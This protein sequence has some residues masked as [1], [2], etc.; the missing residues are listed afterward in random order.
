MKNLSKYLRTEFKDLDSKEILQNPITVLLGVDENALKAL[1][2]INV[3]TVFDL[4]ASWLFAN[5]TTLSEKNQITRLADNLD[6]KK[7]NLLKLNAQYQ[8]VE[9]IPELD[10]NFLYGI[11][12]SLANELKSA[13]DITTIRDFAYWP[14]RLIAHK[15][16]SGDMGTTNEEIDEGEIL[17]PKLGEYPT[18][19]VYF[20]SLTMLHMEVDGPQ[21]PIN[22]PI[23]LIPAINQPSGFGKPAVGVLLTTSQSWYAKG[24]TL[25]HMLHSLA[26]APGEATRIAVVDWSRKTSAS[27]TES[28]QQ[29]ESLNNVTNH[30]RAISEVQN[31][32]AKE[33]QEGQSMSSG[34]AESSSEANADAGSSGLIQSVL[35]ESSSASHSKQSSST[36]SGSV[37]TSWSRGSRDISSEMTQNVNDRTEQHANSVRNRR[38]TA[39]REVSQSEHESVSTRIVANYNH[40]HALTIQYY[41][42][43]QVYKVASQL[44]DAQRC[45]FIPFEYLDFSVP[46]AMD[47]VDRFRGALV[48]AALNSRARDLL[49]DTEPMVAIKPVNRKKLPFSDIAIGGGTISV[50][51][52][53]LATD[54]LGESPETETSEREGFNFEKNIMDIRDAV[55]NISNVIGRAPNRRGSAELYLPANTELLGI[56][57][58]NLSIKSIRADRPGISASNN[59]FN[60]NPD[61]GRIDFPVRMR[62]SDIK[63]IYLAKSKDAKEEGSVTLICS[64]EG[65]SFN[66]DAMLVELKEGTAMQKMVTFQSDQLDREKELLDHLQ[67]NRAHY[68]QMVFRLLDTATLVML[69][70]P[71]TWNG[72]SLIDQIEPKPIAVAGNFL[73]FKAPIENS[74][75]S[76]IIENGTNKTWGTILRERGIDFKISNIRLVPIPTAG[77][78][79]EA[80]LGRSN[81]AEKLDITRFWNWQDSPIPLQPSEISPI[82]LE[83]RGIQENLT[84]GDLNAPVLNIVNPTS[85]PDPAGLSA[86]LGAIAN[87]NIFRNM[88]GLQGTQSIIESAIRE[89]IAAAGQAGQLTT[90]NMQTEAQKQVALSQIAA[91][92]AKAALGIPSEKSTKGISADGAKVNLGRDMDKRGVSGKGSSGSDESTG[93]SSGG[94]VNSS[95]GSSG[96]GTNGT[97][98]PETRMTGSSRE[99]A[100]ADHLSLGYSPGGLN[101][102]SNLVGGKTILADYENT[103]NA[104]KE[105]S[106]TLDDLKKTYEDIRDKMQ[107]IQN[108]QSALNNLQD[109]ES[110]RKAWMDDPSDY[111]KGIIWAKKTAE[112]FKM[113]QDFIPSLPI[114]DGNYIKKLLGAVPTYVNKLTNLLEQRIAKIDTAANADTR[115]FNNDESDDQAC[116]NTKLTKTAVDIIMKLDATEID[117]RRIFA[118]SCAINFRRAMIAYINSTY[119]I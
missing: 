1:K 106:K 67:A 37:S 71:F 112:G 49:A 105:I 36:S 45:L 119:W 2:K 7:N 60:V 14:P 96:G 15:L 76:G 108:V 9:D 51:T 29:S 98:N 31:A 73:V 104:V 116:E 118:M 58:D 66:S 16:L 20:N 27:V 99:A 84:P 92:I 86:S 77:V 26:L 79:A 72:I 81:S 65:R 100:Y 88:S 54:T 39:V 64:Y 70:S 90:T 113:L 13:L 6:L 94:S 115:Y 102:L 63:E 42:V 57:F 17:R 11:T 8:S 21:N 97:V 87:G 74:E 107:T 40:M 52:R 23:S 22:S 95:E 5:A 53:S 103:N 3:E 10:L 68:S 33:M 78:F 85:L 101:A 4:G 43:V 61:I 109:M 69:I 25:G 44:H 34:W 48:R 12:N 80:V 41:E 75:P 56:S 47:I 35:N 117:K 114:A 50:A 38:A 110:A 59:T 24:V 82:N 111:A 30:S 28:I 62:L 93:E 55:L 18:E 19:R 83:S 91:D 46:N 89:T 32:V